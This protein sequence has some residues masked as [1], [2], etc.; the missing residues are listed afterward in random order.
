MGTDAASITVGVPRETFPGDS[1]VALVPEALG[2]RG[3]AGI[4]VLI[5]SGAGRR[6]GI[7]DA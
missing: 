5:E 6:A 7:P 4:K 3:T 2:P 1:R